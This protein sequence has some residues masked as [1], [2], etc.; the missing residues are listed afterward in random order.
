[1]SKKERRANGDGSFYT[2]PDG[3][4]QFRATIGRDEDGKPIRKPF[5]GKTQA[6]CRRKYKEFIKEQKANTFT[7]SPDITLKS[8]SKKYLVSCRKD[9]GMKASSYHQLELL[10]KKISEDLMKKKVSEIKKIEL[11]SFINE[12]SKDASKSYTDKM[13]SLICAMFTEAVE[14]D[15]CQKDPARKLKRPQKRQLPR[16]SYQRTEV[17]TIMEFALTY[18]KHTKSDKINRGAILIS[19]AVITLLDTGIRRGELLGLMPP[20]VEDTVLHI[21]RGV[22]LGEDGVP[23]VDD[24]IAKTYA[25]IRD[26]PIDKELADL[27]RAIPKR[28]LYIFSSYSGRIMYPKNFERAYNTFFRSLRTAHPEVRKLTPHC[29]RHTFATLSQRN[30]ANIRSVQLALGHTN[31]NTTAIY[32]HPDEDDVAAAG[33]AFR[34]YVKPTAEAKK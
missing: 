34:D 13:Y 21:R 26:V 3:T 14:N 12:F 25:S 8:W 1:M 16:A 28:G 24:G 33:K 20:D 19:T 30:G 27:I 2:R 7:V 11:Q 6:E 31:I 10:V 23:T 32:S 15:V 29:C 18:R 22:Y 5:Y 9:S 17:E 4:V